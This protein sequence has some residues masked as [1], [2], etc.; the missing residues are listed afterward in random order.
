MQ[1]DLRRSDGTRCDATRACSNDLH[2][3]ETAQITTND[4]PLAAVQPVPC[5]DA[6]NLPTARRLRRVSS[7]CTVS[8]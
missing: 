1:V 6:A 8:D 2:A 5:S 3:P 7:T 4:M